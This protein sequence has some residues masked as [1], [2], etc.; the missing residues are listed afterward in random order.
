MNEKTGLHLILRERQRQIIEE[1]WTPEHDSRHRYHELAQA[2]ECYVSRAFY[3]GP[4]KEGPPR[5]PWANEWWKPVK[6][7]GGIRNLV[8]AGALIAAEIDGILRKEASDE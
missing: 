4:V 1:G 8:K 5:W 7:D 6:D 2:A 3:T